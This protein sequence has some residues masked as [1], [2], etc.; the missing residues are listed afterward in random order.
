MRLS[1]LRDLRVKTLDGEYLGRV[2]EVHCKEGVVTALMVGPGSLIERLTAKKHG[3]RVPWE[4]VRRID[5]K[6][7]TVSPDPPQKKPP[8]KTSGPRSRRRTRQAS[9]RR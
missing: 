8:K 7:V 6:A 2:H 1:E 9:A 5:R 3:R 4:F